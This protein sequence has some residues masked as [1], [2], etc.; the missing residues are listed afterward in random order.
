MDFRSVAA[1]TFAAEEIERG[2]AGRLEATANSRAGRHEKAA[3]N[4]EPDA[5]PRVVVADV[6]VVSVDRADRDSG[7]SDLRRAQRSL[8]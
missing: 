6:P 1:A 7:D 5:V 3:A 4:R 8:R 2:K